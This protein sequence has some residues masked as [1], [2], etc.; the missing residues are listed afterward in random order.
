M[1][2]DSPALSPN[3][4]QQNQSSQNDVPVGVSSG[5]EKPHD[6]SLVLPLFGLFLSVVTAP[7]GFILSFIA[8]RRSQP[9]TAAWTIALSGIIVSSILILIFVAVVFFFIRSIEEIN[10][11]HEKTIAAYNS[12]YD[13]MNV[14]SSYTQSINGKTVFPTS[15]Q[16]LN[17]NNYVRFRPFDG[18]PKNPRT[19]EYALCNDGTAARFGYW[20]YTEDTAKYIYTKVPGVE[21]KDCKVITN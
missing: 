13:G 14:A 6:T 19:V 8:V 16:Q 15:L 21:P 3:P 12:A 7:V 9:R 18:P 20:N 10:R 4:P 17:E 2:K 1:K 11:N 5:Y